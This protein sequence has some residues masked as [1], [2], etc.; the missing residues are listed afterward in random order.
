[1]SHYTHKVRPAASVLGMDRKTI[2]RYFDLGLIKKV[3][4]LVDLKEVMRA[5]QK[6]KGRGR[7][8]W[9]EAMEVA[10]EPRN[11]N[12]DAQTVRE[13][14]YRKKKKKE[15]RTGLKR[16]GVPTP[17]AARVQFDFLEARGRDSVARLGK[18]D[19]RDFARGARSDR[20]FR[21]GCPDFSRRQARS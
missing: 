13:A 20:R 8:P 10:R 5:R 1:M 19:H 7:V 6:F 17:H 18:L 2:Q 14:S 9:R 4:G 11:A 15:L 12:D 16:K 21:G 3:N